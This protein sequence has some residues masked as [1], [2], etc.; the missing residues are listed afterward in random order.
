MAAINLQDQKVLDALFT[1][2]A[3]TKDQIPKYGA[4][5]AA[6]KA[7][8]EVVIANTPPGPDQSAAIRQIRDARMTA[9]AAIA[10]DGK[11]G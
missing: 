3:P 4:I 5:N 8:A 10:L 2:H 1:Y 7:F 9:N 11:I 6:A